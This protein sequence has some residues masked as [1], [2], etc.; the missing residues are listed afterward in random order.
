M[1][2]VG[3]EGRLVCLMQLLFADAGRMKGH[4]LLTC[5]NGFTDFGGRFLVT[6]SCQSGCKGYGDDGL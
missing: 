4:V 5:M 1:L 3:K 2:W 6:G